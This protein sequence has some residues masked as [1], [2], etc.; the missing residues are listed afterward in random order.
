MKLLL[1]KLNNYDAQYSAMCNENSGIID[2]LILYK[3][4][5]GYFMVVNAGNIDKN[6]KWLNNHIIDDVITPIKLTMK[7]QKIINSQLQTNITAT[8]QIPNQH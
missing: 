1:L 4:P 3:K 7:F 6:F 5:D 8:I 2:D